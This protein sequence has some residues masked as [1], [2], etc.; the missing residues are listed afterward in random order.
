MSAAQIATA[1]FE[2]YG[3]LIQKLIADE[4]ITTEQYDTYYRNMQ[5]I[6]PKVSH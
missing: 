6:D 2:T 4:K 1:P 3:P 5:T